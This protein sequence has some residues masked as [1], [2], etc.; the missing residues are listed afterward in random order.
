VTT[1]PGS[2]R[3]SPRGWPDGITPGFVEVGADPST[4][5][6]FQAPIGSIARFGTLYYEKIGT[7]ATSWVV[8]P[9]SGATWADAVEAWAL[10]IVGLTAGRFTRF[11]ETFQAPGKTAASSNFGERW[12][13]ILAGG[14]KHRTA[15]GA[16]WRGGVAVVETAP[17]ADNGVIWAGPGLFQ[18]GASERGAVVYRCFQYVRPAANAFNIAIV[19]LADDFPVAR[20]VNFGIVEASNG[21]FCVAGRTG[22]ADAVTTFP[23]ASMSSAARDIAFLQVGLSWKIYVDRTL[24]A[25]VTT[26]GTLGDLKPII[27]SNAGT[28]VVDD[29]LVLCDG[30]FA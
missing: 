27:Y 22:L 24:Y 8:I 20:S 7:T 23:I 16:V 6:G 12:D 4:G 10:P 19:G 5:S 1:F 2:G 11:H 18:D 15:G 3:P 25:T 13:V 30:A 28:L 17:W 26:P 21:T 9:A 14:P 29:V